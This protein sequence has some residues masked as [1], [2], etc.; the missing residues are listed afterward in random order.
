MIP[1]AAT[2][3]SNGW[4][5]PAVEPTKPEDFK[6][7][8]YSL[9]CDRILAAV[10]VAG[11]ALVV[12]CSAPSNPPPAAAAPAP[13]E[14]G[15]YQIVVSQEGERGTILFLIDTKDGNSWIYHAP[16]GLLVNGI[17]VDIPRV[18]YPQTYW[19]Q[20]LGRMSQTPPGS[21]RASTGSSRYAA[22]GQ[23]SGGTACSGSAPKP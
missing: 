8:R 23:S 7:K 14:T 22:T 13:T 2:K 6:M 4:D 12:S 21:N 1:T 3:Q 20:V 10:A 15:R 17:W 19:P 18:T 11:T 9:A 5:G 16:Q